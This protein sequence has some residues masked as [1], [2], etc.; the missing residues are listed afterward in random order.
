[1][2]DLDLEK[3]KKWKQFCQEN[4]LYFQGKGIIEHDEMIQMFW[5][6]QMNWFKNE[7][8]KME[9]EV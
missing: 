4:K 3:L 1:M 7:L 2:I 5:Y 6:D 9:A 8:R